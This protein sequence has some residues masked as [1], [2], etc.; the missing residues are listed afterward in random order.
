MAEENRAWGYRRIQGAL[1]NLGIYSRTTRLRTRHR[2][3]AGAQSKD[4]RPSDC[5]QYFNPDAISIVKGATSKHAGV[6][7]QFMACAIDGCETQK[8][9]INVDGFTFH[10]R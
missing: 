1:S 8:L 9:V 5:L 7:Q 4:N 6:Y 3:C 2:A 10:F